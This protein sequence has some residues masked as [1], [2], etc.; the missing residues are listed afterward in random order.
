MNEKRVKLLMEYYKM[1]SLSFV[2]FVTWVVLIVFL[3]IYKGV[4][5]FWYLFTLILFIIGLIGNSYDSIKIKGE[6]E[7]EL[8]IQGIINEQ[9]T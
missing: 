5:G 9:K 7:K 6:I 2:E 3:Y 8:K 1:R 4:F